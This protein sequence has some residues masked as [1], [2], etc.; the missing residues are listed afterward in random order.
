[1]LVVAEDASTRASLA[2]TFGSEGFEVISVGAPSEGLDVARERRCDVVAVDLLLEDGS[3]ADFVGALRQG[4]SS[5]AAPH[6]LCVVP[7][8]DSG[9]AGLVVEDVV[10]RPTPADRLFAALERAGAPRGRDRPV[11]VLDG[12]YEFLRSTGRILE[13]LGYRPVEEADSDR[14]LRSCAEERPAAVVLSPFPSGLDAF[15]F[16]RHLRGV[17]GLDAVPVLL[18]TPRAFQ[19][20]QADA[21]RA[22]ARSAVRSG[23][24]RPAGMLAAGPAPLAAAPAGP[25]V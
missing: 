1:M 5:R 15:E 6:V 3:A 2:W 14:A 16:L 19:A 25:S 8:P 17:T 13:V 11:L 23:A 18:S 12:D 9:P 20:A 7:V 4:G 24:G 21:L 22:A 10:P